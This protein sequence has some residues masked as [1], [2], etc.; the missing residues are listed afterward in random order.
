MVA[1]VRPPPSDPV[2]RLFLRVMVWGLM[3]R[4][5]ML[6]SSSIRPSV[7]K[8][9]KVSRRAMAASLFSKR[10]L[11]QIGLHAQFGKHALQ[12]PVLILQ[13][14]HLAHH[15]C[16]HAA[17]LGP[18]LVKCRAADPVL[19]A[20]LGN[21]HPALRLAQHA[22]DLLFGAYAAPSGATVPSKSVKRFFL[23]GISSSILPRKFYLR[24]PL[25]IGRRAAQ[26]PKLRSSA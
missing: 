14:L 6:E 7:R 20:Q 1:H 16:I 22:H 24:I 15:G 2:K 25:T 5:T 12:P 9:S 11:K 10:L 3:A 18:P 21:R 4:S 8:R 17:K 23:I 19:A 13:R 26:V